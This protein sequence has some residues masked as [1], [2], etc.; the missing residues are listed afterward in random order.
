MRQQSAR[1]L[2]V[3]AERHITVQVLPFGQADMRPWVDR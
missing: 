2:D 1:L 3:A